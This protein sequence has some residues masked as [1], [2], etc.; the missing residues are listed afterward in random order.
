MNKPADNLHQL[1]ISRKIEGARTGK[2]LR[3]DENGGIVVDFPG[4]TL[5]PTAARMTSSVKHRIQGQKIVTGL[6][7]LLVFEN[8]DPKKPVIVDTLCA[9][10]DDA[11][12]SSAISLDRNELENVTIDGKRVTFNAENEIVL[13]CGKSNITLTKA[14]KILIRGAYLLNRSS[15]VNRIKGASVQINWSAGV[16]CNMSFISSGNSSEMRKIV[17]PL[18]RRPCVSINLIYLPGTKNETG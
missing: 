6:E 10:I 11:I 1:K 17:F 14:G 13:K 8:N 4:N 16:E 9:T 7:V 3:M 15:G 12:E 2:I 18:E 5:G